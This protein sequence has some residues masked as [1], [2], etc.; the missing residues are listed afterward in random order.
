LAEGGR[1]AEVRRSA[2]QV[3]SGRA[4]AINDSER[5]VIY[6]M[7]CRSVR[8]EGEESGRFVLCGGAAK[9]VIQASDVREIPELLAGQAAVIEF[10]NYVI[11]NL[12]FGNSTSSD[13]GQL[14]PSRSA[15]A[16]L[17]FSRMTGK[18]ELMLKSVV[19]AARPA[20]EWS[21]R[22]RPPDAQATSSLFR[23]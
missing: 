7:E 6:N 3:N 16:I 21:G 5:T 23:F 10:T 19:T 9:D 20:F 17:G 4:G 13:Q 15:L 12:L 22:S 11:Q 8:H 1:I 18:P 14:R 2:V